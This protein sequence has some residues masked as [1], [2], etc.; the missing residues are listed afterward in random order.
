MS[1]PMLWI[2]S[3]KIKLKITESVKHSCLH[4]NTLMLFMV[5]MLMLMVMLMIML[6]IMALFVTVILLFMVLVMS[7]LAT[8]SMFV[9][10]FWLGFLAVGRI[11]ATVLPVYMSCLFIRNLQRDLPL[12]NLRLFA[13]S[14][15]VMLAV[16]TMDMCMFWLLLIYFVL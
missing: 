11:M 13:P 8:L 10:F 6:M 2:T 9:L 14:F 4:T 5:D 1:S 16:L 15:V 12:I 3:A 7:M